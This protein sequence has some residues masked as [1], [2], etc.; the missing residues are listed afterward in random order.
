MDELAARLRV[1]KSW[2]HV[3]QELVL[4]TEITLEVLVEELEELFLERFGRPTLCK[5]KVLV[6][7]ELT[8]VL[9]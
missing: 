3:R 9:A 5:R 6:V 2:D 7:G 8:E 1:V 4:D